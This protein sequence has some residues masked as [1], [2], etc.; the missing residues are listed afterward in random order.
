MKVTRYAIDIPVPL[1]RLYCIDL[2][3]SERAANTQVTD[4]GPASLHS[5]FLGCFVHWGSPPGR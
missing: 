3:G 2:A 5:T 4:Q 1:R